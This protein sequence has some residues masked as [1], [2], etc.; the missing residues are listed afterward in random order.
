[1]LKEEQRVLLIPQIILKYV[2]VG[3]QQA[4]FEQQ[5]K[6]KA[7]WTSLRPKELS[8]LMSGGKASR[9]RGR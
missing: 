1:M 9:E 5:L 7:I 6:C 4:L 2:S 3:N 8:S